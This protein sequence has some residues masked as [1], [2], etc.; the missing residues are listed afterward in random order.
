M[1]LAAAAT[2]RQRVRCIHGTFTAALIGIGLG[3]LL[4]IV[5]MTSLGVIDSKLTALLPVG[6]MIIAMIYAAAGLSV[7]I[8]TLLVR[9]LVFSPADQL[10]LRP[11]GIQ[12]N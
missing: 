11:T 3:S 10:I 2:A 1:I 8:A 5:P 4:V 9:R 12:G 7:L 6:S